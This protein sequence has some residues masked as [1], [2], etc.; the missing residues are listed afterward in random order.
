MPFTV[1]NSTDVESGKPVTTDVMTVVKENFDDHE[2]RIQ[3]LESG[4]GQTYPPIVFRVGG[5][6]GA[7][8]AMNG[9]LKTTTNFAIE[10]IGV[11]LII[12][13]AGTSGIT[14]I[15]IQRK[16]VGGSY[17]S[18]FSTQPSVDFSEGDDAM[19]DDAVLNLSQ[20]ELSAG[21]ILRLDLTSVQTF[22]RGF[23][24]RID[25]VGI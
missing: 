10:I 9:L 5:P 2:D 16:P 1:I 8:G 6:Y 20:T 14:E 13:E 12:D 24:V 17:N 23:T 22:G 11:Y 25:Y 15:D 21:D 7:Y 4:V 19:S 18:I 3:T